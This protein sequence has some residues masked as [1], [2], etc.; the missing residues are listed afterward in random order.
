[1]AEVN[2]LFIEGHASGDPISGVYKFNDGTLLLPSGQSGITPEVRNQLMFDAALGV[3]MVG[4][5][6]TLFDTF[7]LG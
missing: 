4:S 1:M 7:F 3:L 5:G 2:I 6:E